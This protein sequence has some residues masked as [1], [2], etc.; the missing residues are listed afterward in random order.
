MKTLDAVGDKHCNKYT[1]ERQQQQAVKQTMG[2][3]YQQNLPI[4]KNIAN[5]SFPNNNN[6]YY[7]NKN[8]SNFSCKNFKL[9]H[10]YRK[11]P[12]YGKQ[13]N[14]GQINHFAIAVQ[15]KFVS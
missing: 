2:D 11:C 13:C 14:N 10:E 1:S 15:E 5:K 4:N 9:N 3:K 12:A 6:K 7:V 8:N